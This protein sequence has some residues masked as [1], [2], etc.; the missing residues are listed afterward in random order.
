MIRYTRIILLSAQMQIKQTAASLFI[1]F[2]GVMQP[3][4]IAII[5]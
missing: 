2:N 4:F 5:A 3:F 1:L